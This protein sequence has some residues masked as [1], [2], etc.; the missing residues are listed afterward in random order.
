L[1]NGASST[2]TGYVLVAP[3]LIADMVVAGTALVAAGGVTAVW[4]VFSPTTAGPAPWD[5]ATLEAATTWVTQG[6]IDNAFD[7]QRRR[8]TKA[9][10]RSL[11]N[12]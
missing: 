1:S 7:T 9:T 12:D 5:E 11:I 10:A 8:G 3:A 6:Y 2:V 4:A